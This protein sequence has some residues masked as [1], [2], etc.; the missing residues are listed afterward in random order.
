MQEGHGPLPETPIAG[1]FLFSIGLS[2]SNHG[3]TT[4]GFSV[5]ALPTRSRRNEQI[6][7]NELSSAAGR[8]NGPAG[9]RCWPHAAS[10]APTGR[11]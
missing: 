2:C 11:Y 5:R 1:L 3:A 10:S 7:G 4:C 8:R 9:R 6:N